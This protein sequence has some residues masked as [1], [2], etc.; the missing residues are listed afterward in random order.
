MN[1]DAE[2]VEMH[3][4]SLDFI[5]ICATFAIIFHHYQEFL[6]IKFDY[7]NFYYGMFPYHSMV[8]LFFIISGFFI[9]KYRDEIIEKKKTFKSF[10]KRRVNRL[11]PMTALTALIY[12]VVLII[13]A[14]LTK[15]TFN[16]YTTEMGISGM[17][18]LNGFGMIVTMIGTG[19]G[20]FWK[21]PMA[22][23]VTWYICVLFLCYIVFYLCCRITNHIHVSA[24]YVFVGVIMVGLAC[25]SYGANLPFFNANSLQGYIPFFIGIMLGEFM[26]KRG[27]FSCG[28]VLVLGM[29]GLIISAL[30]IAGMILY[31][32]EAFVDNYW[33]MFVTFPSL[34]IVF[35]SKPVKNVFRHQIWQFLGGGKL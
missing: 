20:W 13:F 34:I 23:E 19:A 15:T 12:E 24:N 21:G 14:F 25:A 8:F 18:I 1:A 28:I 2:K 11:L 7:I 27:Y 26:E 5:K 35:L 17:G 4:N 16:N 30:Y 33:L 22:N 29:A 3:F 10:I 31:T 32:K 9:S 6:K